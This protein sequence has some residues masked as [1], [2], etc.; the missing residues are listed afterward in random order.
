VG[1][2]A[3]AL[4]AA[5]LL[6][7]A[8]VHA[9]RGNT[10][11]CSD[12]PNQAAAQAAPRADPSDPH[13]LDAD[14]DGLA[15]ERNRYPCD[16]TPVSRAAPGVAPAP[17]PA[18]PRP[19][20]PTAPAPSLASPPAAPEPPE[21]DAAATVRRVVDGDTIEV[22]FENGAFA[23][24]RLIGVNT[25]ETVDPRRPVECF[26][27]EA[28][29]R[30]HELLD[31]RAVWLERDVSQTDRFGRLLRYVWLD[32]HTLANDRLV[33]EGYAQVSTFPPDVRYL[34]TFTAS[35]RAAQEAGRGLWSAC[36]N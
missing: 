15:C 31:G 25:P 24:V 12:F 26:G 22:V 32:T 18:A 7:A 17:A 2:R 6:W 23:T 30:M 28:S 27:A 35:Q 10:L 36:P 29:T 16:R 5:M 33:A 9:Q 13:R 11:N 3:L 20:A 19:A 34:E 21:T 8:P 4:V 14:W 1:P